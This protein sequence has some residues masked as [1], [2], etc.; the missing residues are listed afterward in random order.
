VDADQRGLTYGLALPEGRIAP[1]S[2]PSQRL[3]CLNALA[4]HGSAEGQKGQH[5]P[6]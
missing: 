4:L 1:A 3:R 2:G 6:A 5:G